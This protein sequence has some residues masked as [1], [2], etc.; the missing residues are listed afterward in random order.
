VTVTGTVT[1][2]VGTDTLIVNDG[3]G[4]VRIFLD[5]Y[6]GSFADIQVN[7]RVQVFGL[8]SEDGD[9]ARIRVRNY[10]FHA[11]I[12]DDVIVLSTGSNLYLPLIVR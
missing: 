9:G 4:P 7:S 5:G 1:G 12:D 11:G 3:S 6:N 2:K 8:A 10:K